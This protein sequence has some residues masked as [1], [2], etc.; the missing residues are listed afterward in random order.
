MLTLKTIIEAHAQN[1]PNVVNNTKG[2]IFIGT[3]HNGAPKAELLAQ[4]FSHTLGN[5]DY[6]KQLEPGCETIMEINNAFPNRARNM[7]LISF[8][9]SSEMGGLLGVYFS[10]IYAHL[11]QLIV[12]RSSAMLSYGD[13]S[14]C[15]ALNGDHIQIV[16]YSSPDDS[17]YRSISDNIASMVRRISSELNSGS[18]L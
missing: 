9:E 1:H 8:Y 3:P 5:R 6:M 14:R 7:Q 17:N 4:L 13:N 16:K 10:A 11:L 15:V 18:I 2:I 12:P